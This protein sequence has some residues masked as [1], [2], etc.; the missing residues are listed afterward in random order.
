VSAVG[1][2]LILIGLSGLGR[3]NA[4]AAK[5]TGEQEPVSQPSPVS[6][7]SRRRL[8]DLGVIAVVLI[9]GLMLLIGRSSDVGLPRSL[10]SLPGTIGSWRMASLDTAPIGV[11]EDVVGAYPTE[12]GFRTFAGVD[13]QISLVY[14]NPSLAQLRLYVGYYRRQ[15]EGREL[16]GDAGRV[17]AAA[18]TPLSLTIGS[19]TVTAREVVRAVDGVQRGI[20]YWYDINGRIVSDPYRAKAYAIW[21]GLTRQRTNGAIVMITWDGPAAN[22]A[23]RAQAMS[24]ARDLLPA[25]RNHFK[26]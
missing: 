26:G 18:S 25:L 9:A 12:A 15:E 8:L 7:L 23:G 11:R 17:L 21:D 5:A 22:P 19:D 20:L 3:F 4:P 6:P 2:A 24:F 1:Y 16:V 10:A 13:E 14:E